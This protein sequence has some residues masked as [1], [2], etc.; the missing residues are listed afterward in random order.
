VTVV[1]AAAGPL[2]VSVDMEVSSLGCGVAL[3][4]LLVR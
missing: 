1:V 2:S 3:R 4:P